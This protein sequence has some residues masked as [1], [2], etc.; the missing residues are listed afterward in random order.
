MGWKVKRKLF[1][2]TA[3]IGDEIPKR[4]AKSVQS[5]NKIMHCWKSYTNQRTVKLFYYG[6]CR[7]SGR[8]RWA[9]PTM[10]SCSH[11]SG[12]GF[13]AIS[14]SMSFS[15]NGG[16]FCFHFYN[17]LTTDHFCQPMDFISFI[18]LLQYPD[19]YFGH[20][21]DLTNIY[22]KINKLSRILIQKICCYEWHI[23]FLLK[24]CIHSDNSGW[25]VPC[26]KFSKDEIML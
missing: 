25:R 6:K 2:S 16:Q 3:Y 13:N 19:Q 26:Y 4:T 21:R 24:W 14:P 18:V 8:I 5:I 10:L 22:W 20:S 1:N 12:V 23:L 7:P 15:V 11:L 17:M 9:Y